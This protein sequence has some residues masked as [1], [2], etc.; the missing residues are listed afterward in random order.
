MVGPWVV[1]YAAVHSLI[2]VASAFCAEFPYGP[3]VSVF[4][5]E[6]GD[7]AIEGVAVGSLGIGLAGAGADSSRRVMSVFGGTRMVFLA[8]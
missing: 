1:S 2:R 6:E 3:V 7:Q 5:I 8:V 4:G